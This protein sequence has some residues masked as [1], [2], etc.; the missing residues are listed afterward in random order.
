MRMTRMSRAANGLA[1][2][3]LSASL[4]VVDVLAIRDWAAGSRSS[5]DVLLRHGMA[6]AGLVAICGAVR[7]G[8]P[9]DVLRWTAKAVLF[10]P[11]AGFALLIEQVALLLPLGT[12]SAT[13][14][15]R[16]PP[17]PAFAGLVDDIREG[18]RHALD[19]DLPDPLKTTFAADD[20]PLQQRMIGS[21]SRHYRPEMR[22]GLRAALASD[23]PAIRV[24]AAAVY[25]K[26]RGRFETQAKELLALE[27]AARTAAAGEALEVARSGFVPSES[28]DALFAMAQ[29]PRVK[30]VPLREERA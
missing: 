2:L 30:D 16:P 29:R 5:T 19:G 11:L 14:P 3:A 6:I 24:Q 23:V 18:R 20:L 21:I 4:C 26:L 13:E 12:A 25:A 1:L 15:D 27:G 8:L 10:G 17:A 9:D 28:A 22:E 7:R